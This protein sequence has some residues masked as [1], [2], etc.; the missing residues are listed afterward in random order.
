VFTN[1]W[2]KPHD[3]PMHSLSN[4]ITPTLIIPI[5]KE[6]WIFSLL[7]NHALGFH[8]ALL[9]PWWPLSFT[10]LLTALGQSR[11]PFHVGGLTLF[12]YLRTPLGTLG[13][14]WSTVAS[15]SGILPSSPLPEQLPLHSSSLSPW[16]PRMTQAPHVLLE[17]LK[18]PLR[19]HIA[20]PEVHQQPTHQRPVQLCLGLWN[21]TTVVNSVGV[22]S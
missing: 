19:T 1:T 13:L 17:A 3:S 22:P 10:Q 15:R 11:V 21:Q 20:I 16:C 7:P 18:L 8:W 12:T 2:V 5:S 9:V 14:Q 6:V 4:L